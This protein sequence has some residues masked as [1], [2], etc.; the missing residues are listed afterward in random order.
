MTLMSYQATETP[1][2]HPHV[3]A[4]HGIAADRFA[5]DRSYFEGCF[6]RARGS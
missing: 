6:Q 2:Q 4:E 3:A 5:R 1:E